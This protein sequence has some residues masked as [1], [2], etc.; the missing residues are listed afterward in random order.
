MNEA[1]QGLTDIRKVVDDVVIYNEDKQQHMEHMRAILHRC[2]D[3][4]ISLNHDK[5]LFLP[6]KGSVI[7]WN[8]AYPTGIIL[9]Q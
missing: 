5:L 9:R 7:C 1:L 4:Q 6:N 3:Q 2:E 8:A